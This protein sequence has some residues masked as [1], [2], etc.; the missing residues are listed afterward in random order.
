MKKSAL[1]LCAFATIPISGCMQN[2]TSRPEPVTTL[3]HFGASYI[4]SDA[5]LERTKKLADNGNPEAN[6]RLFAHYSFGVADAQN[7][8]IYFDRAVKLEY[9]AALYVKAVQLWDSR[10]ADPLVT[11][12]YLKRA[13]ELGAPDT[14][15]LL[16]TV[17]AKV[18]SESQK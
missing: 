10:R 6:Y 4:L 9:P 18:D 17:Q 3:P 14:A 15:N 16:Q 8:E 7:A 1:I 11:L 13:I 2:S 5:E 12:R